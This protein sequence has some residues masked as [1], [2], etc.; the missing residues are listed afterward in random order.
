MSSPYDWL[1]RVYPRSD[2]RGAEIVATAS[3]AATAV[4]RFMSEVTRSG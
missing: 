4:L 1:K 2:Q 3:S